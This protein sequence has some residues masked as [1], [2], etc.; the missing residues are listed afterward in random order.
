MSKINGP[1]VMLTARRRAM[2]HRRPEGSS[3]VGTGRG[4]PRRPRASERTDRGERVAAARPRRTRMLLERLRQVLLVT[5]IV[6]ALG[7]R[8][9]AQATVGEEIVDRFNALF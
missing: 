6:G 9:E 7:A 4:G 3:R 2:E 8:D 1:I 5:A